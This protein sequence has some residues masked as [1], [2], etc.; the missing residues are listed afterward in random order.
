MLHFLTERFGNRDYVLV[1]D[2]VTMNDDAEF[3]VVA[4]NL[5]GEARTACNIMVEEKSAGKGQRNTSIYI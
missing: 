1:L 2:Y 3:T 4:R 5:M